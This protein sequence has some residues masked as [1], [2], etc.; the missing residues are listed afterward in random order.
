MSPVMRLPEE[1]KQPAFFKELLEL[2]D[3]M[4]GVAFTIFNGWTWLKHIR[5]VDG[6]DK[7]E[8]SAMMHRTGNYADKYDDELKSKYGEA[9]RKPNW[10]APGAPGAPGKT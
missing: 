9:P 1:A 10:A 7:S 8:A 5:E 3:K 6:L 2:N 4:F